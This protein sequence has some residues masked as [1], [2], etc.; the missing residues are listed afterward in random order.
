[1]WTKELSAWLQCLLVQWW[2]SSSEWRITHMILT[3][4]TSVCVI[5]SFFV[6]TRPPRVLGPDCCM[7]CQK[8]CLV[9]CYLLK[10]V[11]EAVWEPMPLWLCL[12]L[13]LVYASPQTTHGCANVS[14][15]LYGSL[16]CVWESAV[17]RHAQPVHTHAQEPSGVWDATV[18]LTQEKSGRGA[19]FISAS[20]CVK[21]YEWKIP[22]KIL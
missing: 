19:R 5:S 1:M 6:P 20:F 11:K 4:I 8:K 10:S 13:T 2:S 18:S 21:P 22:V 17:T 3:L 12:L 9:C 15:V 7:L 16:S 14:N